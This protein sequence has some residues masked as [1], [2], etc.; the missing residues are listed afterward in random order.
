MLKTKA[1]K[2][3]VAF[4]LIAIFVFSPFKFSGFH[5]SKSQVLGITLETITSDTMWGPGEHIVDKWIY[6]K[7]GATLTIQKGTTVK[8]VGGSDHTD[9]PSITVSNGN[10]VAEGTLEE[11]ITFTTA[12]DDDEYGIS[13]WENGSDKT[14]IF[15]NVDFVNGGYL[16]YP[17]TFNT[18]QYL[19]RAYA[20]GYPYPTI[21][22]GS[23]SVRIERS[24]FK[25]S[26]YEDVEISMD[27]SEESDDGYFNVTDSNFEKGQN[28][29][30]AVEAYI[31]CYA[32][33]CDAKNERVKLTNNWYGDPAGPAVEPDFVG[34]GKK[35]IGDYTLECWRT[36]SIFDPSSSVTCPSSVSNVLFLPGLEASRLYT[37]DGSGENQLWEPNRNADVE[38]LFL[39]KDGESTYEYD[40]YTRDVIDEANITPIL[41]KNIY[42]SF[43]AKMNDL[44][45][46]DQVINDWGF[47]AYDWRMPLDKILEDN[48]LENKLEELA[49]G[50][51]SRK[52][53]I[54]AHS[55]GGLLT[56]AL[57]QKIGSEETK[58]L[59]DKI[60]FV[61]VPQV[62]TPD[63]MAAMLHGEGQNIFP[64]LSSETARNLGGNM[65]S[66]YN[67]L[68]S[69]GYFSTVQVPVIVF[70][71][72]RCSADWK[73]R[74]DVEINSKDAL[75]SF[76]I[77]DFRRSLMMGTTL[78][79]PL[80]LNSSLLEKANNQHEALDSWNAPAGVKVV[81]IAGW[82]IPDTISTI[83]YESVNGKLCNSVCQYGLDVLDPEN[84]DSTI[85]GDGTVV[86]PSALW[87][88]GGAERYWTNI[89]LYNRDNFFETAGGILGID[90][91]DILEIPELNNFIADNIIDNT[92]S[93]S[94]YKYLSTEVP[95]SNDEK[96]L[97]YTLHSPLTLNL[98][99]DDEHHTGP[100]EDGYIEEKIPGTY[101]KEIGETKNI[102]TSDE[103]PGRIEMKGYDEGKFTF[104]V[105][106]YQ[107]DEEG[108]VITF[109]DIPTTDKTI[110]RFSTEGDLSR[111]S[112]LE[113]DKD[114]D[115]DIDYSLEPKI[116]EIVT[117]DTTPP[118][119]EATLTGTNGE[120]GWYTNDVTLNFTAKDEDNG[121]GVQ[122]TEYSTNEGGT[123]IIYTDPIEFSQEG[124]AVVK[125]RSIDKQE[126]VEET[127]TATIKIDKTAPEA[128]ISFGKDTKKLEIEGVDN[129][130]PNVFVV[131]E[132]KIIKESIGRHGGW[133]FWS[134]KSFSKNGNKKT[135]ETATL[136]DEAGHKTEV[137]LEKKKEKNGFIDAV[138]KYISYDEQKKD[139]EKNG[140]QYKWALNWWKNKYLF[141]ASS[142][143][144][145]SAIVES[146]Y[147]PRFDQ[148]WIMERPI[149]LLG[150]E[151]DDI[152]NRSVRKKMPGM[153]IPGII[154]SKG[155][156]QVIY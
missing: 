98:Y 13:V 88:S 58:N 137:V 3:F 22:Y 42:K 80:E 56:K 55:N 100:T 59:V 129:L 118:I 70:D 52:V 145:S 43:I 116:G 97:Q 95:P 155:E 34:N 105:K 114:G 153:V 148:T 147:F 57:L 7:N 14:S 113:V 151:K 133:N 73:N 125:Y 76:L 120:N 71:E 40:I 46:N 77:D 134:W 26:R 84:F 45:N 152:G 128:R 30:V 15:S 17:T 135:I 102:F 33:D 109:K 126:N 49:A 104:S 19:Q 75:D 44:K 1:N 83:K 131:T 37:N 142:L 146:H 5:P 144:T 110:A 96:R 23:G 112:N 108:D 117:L 127:K 136:T 53:T 156:L 69:E 79:V 90:H 139:L 143:R 41:Q 149:E 35:I 123:W 28:S 121:S 4:I 111:A 64:V 24:A 68:P 67:L 10:I 21:S 78:N 122:K 54:I 132:E 62:G 86:T 66:A 91:K 101:Y 63:A 85:D 72:E 103:F 87:M 27:I 115:G 124:I 18:K 140:E 92:K 31:Y 38:K 93:L 16:A 61:A 141:F 9:I 99:D 150:D 39:D 32:D 11:R 60:I 81:Q 130:S 29:N 154:T 82:G 106:E 25:N 119:T 2:R 138:I 8:F 12:T 89:K 107:G 48:S 36:A 74:Y 94:E 6:I 50:S 47:F 65:A 51:K 20:Y